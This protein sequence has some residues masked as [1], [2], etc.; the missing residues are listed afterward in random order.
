MLRIL[1][2]NVNDSGKYSCHVR[3]KESKISPLVA[4]EGTLNLNISSNFVY[5]ICNVCSYVAVLEFAELLYVII[6]VSL[7]KPRHMRSTVKSI[8][9]AC[10]L[11]M[12]CLI[13]LKATLV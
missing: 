11:D 12:S 9:F 8:F 13:C 4:E 5:K 2:T 7:C 1:H 3:Y 6:G 10:L